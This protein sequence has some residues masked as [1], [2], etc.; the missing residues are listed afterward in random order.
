MTADAYPKTCSWRTDQ[1]LEQPTM[2]PGQPG[3]QILL[4]RETGVYGQLVDAVTKKPIP[5]EKV[6]L[7]HRQEGRTMPVLAWSYAQGTVLWKTMGGDNRECVTTPTG[8]FVATGLP[9][10]EYHVGLDPFT[11]PNRKWVALNQAVRVDEGKVVRIE[12]QA[13]RP[14]IVK[15]YCEDREQ[16]KAVRGIQFRIV[17]TSESETSVPSYSKTFSSI[18]FRSVDSETVTLLKTALSFD[19]SIQDPTTDEQGMVTL[20][21]VPGR[22]RIESVTREGYELDGAPIEFETRSGEE[23]IL[24][25]PV[26]FESNKVGIWGTCMDESGKPLVG[27]RL[28]ILNKPEIACVS[29]STG[30][31]QFQIPGP[32][33]RFRHEQSVL[34][35]DHPETGTCVVRMRADSIQK[36][37]TIVLK[38]N[39]VLTGQVLDPSGLGIQNATLVMYLCLHPNLSF[40][41][42]LTDPTGYLP[43]STDYTDSTGAFRI[44]SLDPDQTYVLRIQHP[45]YG[46]YNYTVR[47]QQWMVTSAAVSNPGG[48]DNPIRVKPSTPLNLDVGPLTL[49]PSNLDLSGVVVNLRGK[50]VANIRLDL[51]GSEQVPGLFAVSDPNGLFRFDNPCSRQSSSFLSRQSA[52]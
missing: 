44:G 32:E 11:H 49:S 35:A 4:S 23:R 34:F 52:V 18:K 6:Y 9:A 25:I 14:A 12:V 24:K 27:V 10:G 15:L 31:F 29:D 19:Q 20:T 36:D 8:L 30:Y 3:I 21:L 38:P 45:G 7:I 48:T 1:G 26:V 37:H 51:S 42:N 16:S 22:Y 5:N 13:I 47:S 39:R 40:L 2:A 33:D 41:Y 17:S 46:Y 50:P 43:I 28:R